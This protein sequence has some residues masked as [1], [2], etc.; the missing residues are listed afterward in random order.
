M[1]QL[2]C[3]LIL[4]AILGLTV[5]IALPALP[6]LEDSP[7]MDA[8]LAALLCQPGETVQREQYSYR[9]GWRGENFGVKV[10]CLGDDGRRD[11]TDRWTLIGMGTLAIPCILGLVLIINR[12]KRRW[13]RAQAG[14]PPVDDLLRAPPLVG[15]QPVRISSSAPTSGGLSLTDRLKQLQEARDAG[16]LSAQE[17]ERL[18]QEILNEM[19]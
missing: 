7:E 19:T 1:G 18:R 10:Y 13:S 8:L 4:A 17:Y 2:G 9:V 16:L 3:L 12:L 5:L 6:P 15:G 14:A 11:V